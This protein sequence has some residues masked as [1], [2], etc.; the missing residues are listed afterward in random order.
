MEFSSCKRALCLAVLVLMASTAASAQWVMVGRKVVGKISNLAQPRDAKTVGY[1]AATVILE[2][3]AAKVYATAF[4]LLSKNT[5]LAITKRDDAKRSLAF[6][7]GDWVTE[8][9]VSELGDHLCQLLIMASAGPGE[10]AGTGP[11]LDA[12][13]RICDEMGVKYTLE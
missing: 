8:L 12:L 10:G 1:E 13:K 7:Q 3:D 6:R 4:D 2:A 5:K 9:Q 11:T